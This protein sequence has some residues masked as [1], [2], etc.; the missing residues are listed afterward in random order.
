MTK[1]YNRRKDR[2][3]RQ[4][5]RKNMTEAEKIL[6]AEL[7][8]KRIEGR[9]F[10]RQYSIMGFVVDFYCPEKRLAIEVDGGYH[11][12][13]DQVFYDKARQELLET[14][15]IVFLRFTNKEVLTDLELV[16]Q[17]IR[18]QINSSLSLPL[19]KGKMSAAGGQ[20][21]FT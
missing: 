5:L 20:K 17:K 9:K 13:K 12:K 11:K 15:K 2:E 4:I 14:L 18:D 16:T 3:K 19:N 1:I 6:W 10:R 8:L 21:G 7:R